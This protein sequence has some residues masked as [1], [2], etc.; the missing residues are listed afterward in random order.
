MKILFIGKKD[1][2][3]AEM[4]AAYTQELFPDTLVV[5]SRRGMKIPDE[6]KS[7]EGDY[8]FSYLAQWIIPSWLLDKARLGGV[9]WHPGPPA[10]PGIGCTNFAVY[11]GAE[12]FGV[13]CHYM[14][15]KVDT[16]QIIEVAE[17]SV[18][19]SDT[20]LSITKKCY[21][22]ILISYQRQLQ[23]ISEGSPLP[24]AGVQWKRKPYTR[25][26]LDAL[27]VISPDMDADEIQRRV[28]ATKYDRH[29]AYVELG[30]I[31]F[32]ATD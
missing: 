12:T 7:W 23:S 13:T 4:A 6:L 2:P 1:D 11:D 26:E 16:G 8:V 17:F 32:K 3:Q 29:W 25:K 10:Y 21:E 14:K 31:R 20:V 22:H 24:N 5:W 27:C 28:K 15:P 9:N 18:M 19:G 30:G